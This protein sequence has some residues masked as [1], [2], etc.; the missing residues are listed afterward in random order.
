MVGPMPEPWRMPPLPTTAQRMQLAARG[1]VSKSRALLEALRRDR[2]D[3]ST[4]GGRRRGSPIQH[5][6]LPLHGMVLFSTIPPFL[7]HGHRDPLCPH[8]HTP[9][10]R[11]SFQP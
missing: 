7:C 10:Q 4:A 3:F 11:T 9:S 6:L 2:D 1:R 8:P 5:S